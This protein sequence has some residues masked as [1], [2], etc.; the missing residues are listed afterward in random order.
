MDSTF[1]LKPGMYRVR[2]VV[3]DSEEHHITAV[4]RTV[5]VSTECCVP[6]PDLASNHPTSPSEPPTS[7]D[8]TS[9]QPSS[10]SKSVVPPAFTNAP[11]YIDYPLRELSAVVPTLNGMKARF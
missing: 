6:P 2:E 5:N 11:T 1:E 3:T 8:L 7:H 9:S 4:S 10:S